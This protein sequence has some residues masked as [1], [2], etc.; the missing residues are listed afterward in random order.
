MAENVEVFL[1]EHKLQA[2][3]AEPAI[4]GSVQMAR[5][6]SCRNTEPETWF[7]WARPFGG[8]LYSCTTEDKAMRF[9]T[10]RSLRSGTLCSNTSAAFLPARTRKQIRNSISI[11]ET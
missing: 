4:C 8:R 9:G 2:A 6:C 10:L 5:Q 7:F 1:K 11:A 3:A